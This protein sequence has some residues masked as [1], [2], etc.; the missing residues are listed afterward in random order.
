MCV[1]V[2]GRVLE[3]ADEMAVVEFDRRRQRASL[4]LVPDTAVGDW[5]I[6][7]AGTVLEVLDPD[8]AAEILAM[9]TETRSQ[10]VR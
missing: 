3:I 1:A 7:A 5:V 9:I 6:V 8:E 2:P 4:L 10:E